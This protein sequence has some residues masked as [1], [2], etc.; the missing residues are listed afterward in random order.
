M[1]H[2][3]GKDIYRK[4]GKKIDHLAVR[5]P[6]NKALHAILKE[7]Y[8]EEEADVVVKMPYRLSPIGRV[9]KVTGY[10]KT[11]L[12]NI[13][14]KL[15][16]KGLVVDI[17]VNDHYYYMPSPLV[18]GIFEFTMMRTGKNLDSKKWARLFHDYMDSNDLFYAANFKKGEQISLARTIPHEETL[19][20][21]DYV[22]I[23]DFE[24]ATS[25]VEQANQYSIGIC[26]CRHEK[27][28]LGEKKCKAPLNV[29]SSF[30]K[31]ADFLIRNNLAKQA[32]K[33]EMLENL[34][35]SREMGLVFNADNIQK[36][37]SFICHCCGCCCNLLR[38]ISK[39]GYANTVVTSNFIATINQERCIGCGKCSRACPINAIEM[40]RIQNPQMKNGIEKKREPNIDT[41][42]CLGCGVCAL[43]CTRDACQLIPR[44]KRVL[45]PETTFER[46]ILQCLERG[47]LQNQIFDNPQ[48][49]THQF[50][51]GFVGAFLRL[52]FIKK[53]LISD[54]LRSSFLSSMQTGIKGRQ[55]SLMTEI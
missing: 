16:S 1:G 43:Q 33:S 9:A 46:V 40:Q 11:R 2:I 24:R 22:E 32:S 28:H 6:W 29:C 50:M 13:L 41:G 5:T 26:S 17:C 48:N 44:K 45:T 39:H 14:N 38:G 12:R 3:V 34:A 7:L 10:E 19:P 27:M 52:P 54:T 51:R 53:A 4:L 31:G 23:L 55:R 18:V 47:T 42:I 25:I 36:N 49:I 15:C 8:S 30:G 35:Q 20:S 37:I 21:S